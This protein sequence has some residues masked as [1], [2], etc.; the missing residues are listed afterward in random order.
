MTNFQFESVHLVLNFDIE[1]VVFTC[2]GDH[3]KVCPGELLCTLRLASFAM[4]PSSSATSLS[5]IRT[6]YNVAP[7]VWQA[8]V[9]SAGDPADDLKAMA[10]L[11]PALLAT[12]VTA[13]R[14]PSGAALT[15]VQASQVGLVFRAAR[16]NLFLQA[17]GDPIQWMDPNPWET[18]PLTSPSTSPTASGSHSVERKMKFVNVLDQA[19]E[20]EFNVIDDKAHARLMGNFVNLTGGLPAVDEEPTRE[21]LSALHRKVFV[22]N[23]PPYADFAVF[24]PHNKKFLKAMKYRTFLPTMEGGYMAKEVPGPATYSQWL[25]SF[26][27]WRTAMLMLEILDLALIQRYELLVENMVKQLP[28]C[29]HLIVSAEDRARSDQLARFQMQATLELECRRTSSKRLGRQSTVLGTYIQTIDRGPSILARTC[30]LTRNVVASVWKARTAENAC[31]DHGSS[32]DTWRR[33]FTESRGG[34]SAG[35]EV[36]F[37]PNDTYKKAGRRTETKEKPGRRG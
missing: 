18:T 14:L 35:G 34:A 7:E 2:L 15:T 9:D 22:L 23:Q 33:K 13:A 26:R 16:R 5:A 19:D 11:P 8:F 31:G 27:V 30:A 36:D 20:S 25:G 12:C 28:G 37:G 10:S 32:H 6:F 24:T 1:K 29:W 17:G 21:Q 3:T 4:W